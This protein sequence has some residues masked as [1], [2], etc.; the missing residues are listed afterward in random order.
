MGGTRSAGEKITRPAEAANFAAPAHSTSHRTASLASMHPDELRKAMDLLGFATHS[1][2]AAAIGVDRS[3]ISLW[4]EG[5]VGVPRPVSKL[6]R[7]MCELE[8][9]GPQ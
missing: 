9:R 2:L 3:T 7:L 1:A 8:S 5:R 6:L 4:L